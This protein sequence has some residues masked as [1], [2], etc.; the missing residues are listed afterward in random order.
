MSYGKFG[1]CNAPWNNMY[2][3]TQG[4]VAPCWKLPGFADRWTTERSI[5][6]I[7]KGE[8]FQKYRDALKNNEF[9]NRCQECKHEMDGDVWPLAKAY[10]FYRV[11]DNG[12][13]SMIELEMSNQ[14]NLECIMCSP[15]LSSGLAKKQGKPLLEPYDDSF[16]EQLKEYYPH[17]QELRFNGGEPFA[18][19][20][21][22]EICEDVAKINPS[23]PISIATNGT[24]MNKRVKKLLD[25]CEIQINISIDSLIPER[26]E[27]I[28]VNSNFDDLMKNFHIFREY[29]KKNNKM[30]SVMVNPM[31]NNWEEMPHFVDF[32][33]EHHVRLW[34]NT[35][36]YPRHLAMWNLPV[37]ELQ[38]I[39]DKLSSE[40]SKRKLKYEHQKLHHLVEDQIKNW[41]LDAY[42]ED[43]TKKLHP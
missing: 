32:C 25:I 7:W 26:Y 1:P 42:T 3:N 2:F 16:K 40:T 21:V 14:C 41:V 38:K 20:L 27:Q 17:L 22:L 36:L 15:L 30:Y 5:N 35:I 28:R 10:S 37:E 29:S 13:P 11:N 34:F 18:Q 31:R 6:D 9:L 43:K 23:L 8:H 19:R 12:Y 4:E 33:H 24:I 39:Y